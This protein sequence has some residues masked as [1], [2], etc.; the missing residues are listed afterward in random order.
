MYYLMYYALPSQQPYAI[1]AFIVPVLQVKTE[2]SE[3]LSGELTCDR[4]RFA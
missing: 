1:N 3:R 4:T 2:G